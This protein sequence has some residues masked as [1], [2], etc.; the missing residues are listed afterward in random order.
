M[1]TIRK[2]CTAAVMIGAVMSFAYPV[3]ALSATGSEAPADILAQGKQVFGNTCAVCHQ[4]TGGGVAGAF[5]PLAKSDFLAADPRRAIHIVI[6]GLSGKVTVN[7]QHFDSAMPPFGPQLTDR[8]I[9]SVLTYVLNSWGNPGGRIDVKDV[10][11]VR[12]SSAAGK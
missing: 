6:N 10:A 3:A 4:S 12:S 11:A 2:F 8:E 7:G 9:A 5:P 1:S